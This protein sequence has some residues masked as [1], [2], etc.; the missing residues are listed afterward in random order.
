MT[1]AGRYAVSQ[2]ALSPVDVVLTALEITHPDVPVPIRVVND[3]Q[4]QTIEGNAYRALRFEPTLVSDVEGQAPRA[5]I[6]ID[7]VGEAL[8]SWVERSEGGTGAT[9]R[10]M[11]VV[12]G[13]DAPQYDISLE[14]QG[15]SVREQVHVRLGHEELFGRNGVNMRHDPE[16]SP[17]VF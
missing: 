1:A 16:T 9:C 17:G 15:M 11:Q 7:N 6:R 2:R 4:D 12:A 3:A 5:E 14:V 13:E 10:V 8:T